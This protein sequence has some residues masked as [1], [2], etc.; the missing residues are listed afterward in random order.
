MSS[1]TFADI[2]LYGAI[3]LLFVVIALAIYFPPKQFKVRLADGTE[4]SCN[5]L[6]KV[7]CGYDLLDCSNDA[8]YYCVTNF[9]VHK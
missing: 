4:V 5:Q 9:L 6:E 2:L 8:N 3:A 7:D 1:K